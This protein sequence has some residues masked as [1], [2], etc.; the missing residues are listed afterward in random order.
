M[1]KFAVTMALV[2]AIFVILS[3]SGSAC[4]SYLVTKGAS[5]DGSTMITYSA[6]SHT[7]YGELYF[8][9]SSHY[10]EGDTLEVTDWESGKKKGKIPQV[11]E[12]FS[13]TGY[14]N[15]RQ[16]A[17][18]ETTFSPRKE[19][20]SD[21]MMDYGSLISIT[22]Q[23]AS[24][25]REAV[26]IMGE[27][28]EKYGFS[29]TGETFSIA[30]KNEVWMMDMVGKGAEEKGALWVALRIP[31]GYV[32]GHA[33]QSRIRKFPLNDTENC[34]YGADVIS[35][36]R[37]KGYFSGRDD[38]FS[39]ADAYAPPTFSGLRACEA[40]VWQM[41]RRA[42]PSV[43]IPIALVKGTDWKKPE[44]IPLWVKPDKKLSV[45]DVME[46]M[47]DHF[48]GTE[49]D[50]TNGVGSG[51][52]HLPYRWRPLTWKADDREYFNERSASTQQTAF[53]FVTQSRSWLPDA[54]GGLIWFGMDDTYSTVYVPIYSGIREAPKCFAAGTGSFYQFSWDSAFWVFNFVSNY[55]YSR[56]SDMIQDVRKAQ[57]QLEGSFLARQAPVEDAALALYRQSPELARD[58]LTA[59]SARQADSTLSR[60]KL[61]LTQLLMKYLDGNVRDEKGKVTHP[62]YPKDWYQRIVK[63]SGDYYRDRRIEGEPEPE[64]S[65]SPSVK[66]KPVEMKKPAEMQDPAEMKK[67]AEPKKP[68]ETLK[69]QMR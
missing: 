28:A 6:D 50:L 46:L 43:K 68:A 56:Y 35:F 7:L 64:K 24:T 48:E 49:F 59:Y 25:A 21:G 40:R 13:V 69:T 31:D 14:M 42:A 41:F 37:K 51:P 8:K 3:D 22:L 10:R 58:Y 52:Y 47:R 4:T 67:S 1:K 63:E 61:L 5:S 11:T 54:I 66:P 9:P 29:G 36:A 32:S 17:I 62:G 45:H 19:L 18:S 38:E 57:S 27:L 55:S 34:L 30:D 53:S 39:Y 20:K 23:R 60:W 12:T 44:P 65:P 33:N 26:K 2:F 15:E 16:V